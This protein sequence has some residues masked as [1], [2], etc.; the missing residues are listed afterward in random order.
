MS[1]R[2]IVESVLGLNP[3]HSEDDAAPLPGY[4]HDSATP[5]RPFYWTRGTLQLFIRKL[6]GT[7]FVPA[8]STFHYS[9]SDNPGTPG[10]QKTASV[11]VNALNDAFEAGKRD[12]S[13]ADIKAAV[14]NAMSQ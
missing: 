7:E 10:E 6:G 9:S 14:N 1:A 11:A 5:E 2:K 4:G 3:P 8:C 13:V 12:I